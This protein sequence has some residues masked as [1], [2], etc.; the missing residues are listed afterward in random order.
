MK[1]T[2]VSTLRSMN[3][4]GEFMNLSMTD[5][6]ACLFIFVLSVFTFKTSA[7]PVLAFL[8]PILVGLTLILIR[9]Q[10]RRKTIRDFLKKL[11]MGTEIYDPRN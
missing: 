2:Y 5:I 7:Y 10:R 8:P 4:Q 3:E 9:K 6:F 1:S 11:V